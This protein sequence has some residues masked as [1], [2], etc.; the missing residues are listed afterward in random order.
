LDAAITPVFSFARLPA[1]YVT[2]QRLVIFQQF[3]ADDVSRVDEELSAI[4]HPSAVARGQTAPVASSI[5][6]AVDGQPLG[7]RDLLLGWNASLV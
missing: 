4:L 1:A 7:L 6:A 5:F 3:S 2:R